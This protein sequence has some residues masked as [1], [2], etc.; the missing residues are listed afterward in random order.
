M[1]VSAL[2][3]VK[4]FEQM[5]EEDGHYQNYFKKIENRQKWIGP[6]H[7]EHW[8][9]AKVFVQFLKTFYNIIVLF[10]ASLSVILNLYFT[11]GAQ[12]TTN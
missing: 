11:N 2:K 10:S 1:L 5:E 12:L 8:E 7:F 4:T 3:F 6:P 9:K